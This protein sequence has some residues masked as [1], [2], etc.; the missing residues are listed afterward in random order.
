MAADEYY[1]AIGDVLS[2]VLSAEDYI[3]RQVQRRGFHGF[4]ILRNND[5]LTLRADPNSRYFT[6]RYESKISRR[7]IDAYK[8]DTQLLKA[9][10][11]KYDIDQHSTGDDNL[12]KVVAYHRIDDMEMDSE[13]RV[14]IDLSSFSA[15]S[16]CRIR[17]LS[18]F[19][20]ERENDE[21]HERWDGVQAI[22]LLYPYEESFSPRDYEQVAQETISVGNQLDESM[23]KLDIIQEIEQ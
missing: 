14:R 2:Y 22:G 9:H 17:T 23:E 16:D 1:D 18:I 11:E 20:P 15:H 5:L 3:V 8:N 4:E 12:N 7:L 21:E 19:D 13:D 10:I 6:L